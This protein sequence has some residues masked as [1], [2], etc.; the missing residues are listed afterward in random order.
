MLAKSLESFSKKKIKKKYFPG[1]LKA[2]QN[3]QNLSSYI[4][5]EQSQFRSFQSFFAAKKHDKW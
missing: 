3:A 2:S 4:N 5:F 1:L